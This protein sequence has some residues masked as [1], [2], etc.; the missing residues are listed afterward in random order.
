VKRVKDVVIMSE[1]KIVR[2]NLFACLRESAQIW[3][4][5]E[6]SDLEKKALRTLDEET[7]HWCNALLKKFKKS[8]TF[9]L[10]YLIIERY[11]LNNVRANRNISSFVFQIMR[12]AKVVNIA[13]L[14]DQLIWI[15][16]AIVSKLI[17]NINF[18]DENISIMTFLKNLETKKNIWHRIYIRKS[19]SSRIE[20][21]FS[22]YQINSFNFLFFTYEQTIYTQKQYRSLFIENVNEQRNQR[23]Q[24][25]ENAY[26]KDK[27]SYRFQK[28]FDDFNQF[29]SFFVFE[30][31]SVRN[32]T[33]S[34]WRQ[35]ASQENTINDNIFRQ[36]QSQLLTNTDIILTKNR[37]SLKQ[38]NIEEREQYQD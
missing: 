14:H 38:F 13:D 33:I 15:Y 26:Q 9:V 5:E 3:Y 1:T 23:F 34:A 18:F 16:N 36:S 32:Q 8:M 24:S 17:K 6:L 37:S 25:N 22:Q 2:T 29:I 11:I 7:N 35:N 10:N 20:S 4:I 28:N 21:E 27:T 30:T 31:Q 12:H 19:I